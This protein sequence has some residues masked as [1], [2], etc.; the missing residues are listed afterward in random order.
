MNIRVAC[1]LKWLVVVSA[2]QSLQ[3]NFVEVLIYYTA[4]LRSYP[5]GS[6]HLLLCVGYSCINPRGQLLLLQTSTC[7]THLVSCMSCTYG[8][9][10]CNWLVVNTVDAI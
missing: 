5:V 7:H 6:I 4:G 9:Q 2:S 8:A 3:D 10:L 1:T